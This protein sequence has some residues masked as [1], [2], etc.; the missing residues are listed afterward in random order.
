MS[1]EETNRVFDLE[2]MAIHEVEK[3][4]NKKKLRRP[5]N[6]YDTQN[7][8]NLPASSFT[9]T[10]YLYPVHTPIVILPGVYY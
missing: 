9:I 8:I 4:P 1:E 6:D 5:L 3:W 10:H 2:K 7:C